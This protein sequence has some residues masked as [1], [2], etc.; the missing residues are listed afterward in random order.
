MKYLFLMM[1]T[2]TLL[3]P[4]QGQDTTVVD[5]VVDDTTVVIEDSVDNGEDEVS[6]FEKLWNFLKQWGIPLLGGIIALIEVIVRITPSEK[7]NAWLK[8][9]KDI[10]DAIIPN[11]KKGGG[12]HTS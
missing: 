10:F 1:M 12:T 8:W 3:L 2:L 11:L 4:L 7:D 5:T 6:T 9:L